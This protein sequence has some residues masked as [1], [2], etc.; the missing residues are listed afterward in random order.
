MGP[1][2]SFRD[3]YTVGQEPRMERVNQEL[4]VSLW[5]AWVSA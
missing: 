2:T 3:P 1:P 4:A 5:P